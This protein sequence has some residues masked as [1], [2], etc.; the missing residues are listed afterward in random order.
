MVKAVIFDMDGLLIDSEPFW[1]KAE[2]EIFPRYGHNLT[3]EDCKMMQ[4]I[5]IREVV[6]YW[7][8]KKPW[9]E[10]SPEQVAE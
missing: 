6:R 5:S 7:Y 8:A 3:L 4:G 2:I 1:A 10:K 9:P